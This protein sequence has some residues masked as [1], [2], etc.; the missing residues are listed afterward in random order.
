VAVDAP[1]SEAQRLR[2]LFDYAI[3]DTA[4]EADFDRFV[5]L[6]A[7]QLRTPIAAL[8]FVDAERVWMKAET[9][10]GVTEVPRALAFCNTTIAASEVCLVRDAHTDPRFADSALVRAAPTLR[11]HAGAPL[12]TPS[13][14]RIGSLCVMDTVPRE[15][16]DS[17]DLDTLAELASLVVTQLE[18]RRER[19]RTARTARDLAIINDI[20]TLVTDTH[21]LRGAVDGIIGRVIEATGAL[22]GSLLELRRQ[23]GLVHLVTLQIRPGV[24]AVPFI[25]AHAALPV[26]PRAISL[27][28]LFGT[29]DVRPTR[30]QREPPGAE[31]GVM[32]ALAGL[33]VAA[34]AA[35]SLPVGED[36]HVLVLGFD[37]PAADLEAVEVLLA[38]LRAPLRPVLLRKRAEESLALLHAALSVTQDAV[39]ITEA[40]PIDQPGPR[41]VFVN[42][43]FT[44]M[45]GWEPC[46]VIGRTPRLLQSEQTDRAALDRIRAALL[47]WQPVREELLN[48]RRDGTPFWVEIEI[49]PLA[50]ADGWFTHWVAVQRDITAQ[51]A[52]DERLLETEKFKALGQL[53]GGLAHDF[54][55]LLTVIS[56]NLEIA[57][58][59]I[60][61]D[62]PVLDLIEPAMKAASS[63][64]QL[65]SSLLSFARR[66]PLVARTSDVNALL[67]EMASLA[68][69]TLGGRH[70][71]RLA[72]RPD[73]PPCAIDRVQF[74]SAVLKLL[75]NSRDAMPSGGE[76]TLGSDLVTV[77]A[78]GTAALPDLSPGRYVSVAVT[79][80]GMGIPAELREKVFEPFF[81]TKLVGQGTG[82]GLSMAMGFAR[83]SGGQITLDSVA[84]GGTTVRLLLPAAATPPAAP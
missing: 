41:I 30:V 53:T 73:L 57:T 26:P 79:D 18:L 68:A 84:G 22:M 42:P 49:T 62:H 29:G 56:L 61:D 36:S 65:T 5:R 17:A 24:D 74:E 63:G 3:L 48:Q 4:A 8:T 34:S 16:I 80:T 46:E 81:T 40:E 54:N 19:S 2:A 31:H 32:S 39:L 83:Q 14:H 75:I 51:R 7:R 50:G 71:I 78:G 76:I 28:D 20:L 9:G 10:L 27:A 58:D 82:L 11:F 60:G 25:A 21:T 59:M 15:D 43:G 33:G 37:D 47:A 35:L 13:G 70:P 23:D 44:R 77:P 66:Q 1:A 64:A 69:R 55:N 38:Q 45:T 72:L 6:A 67:G 12:T 52:A